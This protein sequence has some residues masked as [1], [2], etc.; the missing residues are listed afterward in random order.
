MQR[1][2]GILAEHI[3]SQ[4]T[5]IMNWIEIRKR[6]GRPVSEKLENPNRKIGEALQSL[7]EI[8]FVTPYT[9]SRPKNA[10]D[11]ECIL[12]NKLIEITGLQAN[13]DHH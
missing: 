6:E 11:I 3:A 8:S 12:Q 2:T 10:S 1:L 4:N 13:K 7:S 5:K 9:E